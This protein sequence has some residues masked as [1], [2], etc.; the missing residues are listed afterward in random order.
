[1]LGLILS[2]LTAFA[3]AQLSTCAV[4]GTTYDVYGQP[5]ANVKIRLTRVEQSGQVISAIAK[6]VITATNGTWSMSVP[7]SST[8]WFCAPELPVAGISSNCNSPTKKTIPNA[9]SASFGALVTIVQSPTLGIT[10]K[11]EGTALANPIGTF[12]FVGSGVAVTESATGVATVTINGGGGG[13]GAVDSV[14]GRTGD[15]VAATNDYTFAQIDKTTS[16]LADLTTRSASDLSSGTLPDARFPATLPA[17]SGVNL[18]ALNASNLASGTVPLAR[19]SGIT[20]SQ[21]SGTAGITNA[22]LA[23]SIAYS[24]LSLTDSILNADINSAAAIAYSKLNLTGSILNADLAGSIANAKLANSGITIAGTSTSLGSAITLDT[25]TGLSSTGLVKRSGANTFAIAT[26]GTDYV[27]PGAATGSGLTMA[28]ARLLGR[29]TAS[30][31]AIEEITVGSGLSL[32]GGTLTASGGSGTGA[33]PSAPVG[34]SAVNGV[35]TTFMRSDGAPALSQSIVPTWTGIH[36]FNNGVT[37]GTTTTAGT[38]FTYNSLSTGTGLYVGS[39]STAGSSTTSALVDVSRSGAQ[40]GTVTTTAGRFSNTATGAG[41]TNN[42]LVLSASG[43]TAANY[44]LNVTVGDMWLQPTGRFFLSSAG[45]TT[46]NYIISGNTVSFNN[47][48]TVQGGWNGSGIYARRL[49]LDYA[50]GD[51]SLERRAARVLG[52]AQGDTSSTGPATISSGANTPAQITADQNNYTPGVGLFQRWSSDAA[53][54]VTGLLAGATDGQLAVI[55]NVG[56]QNIILANE[57]ASSTAANRFT[58]AS[59]ADITLAGGNVAFATYST[60]TSRW[61]VVKF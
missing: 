46:G 28:T 1:M 32:S 60:A 27:A 3:Q 6:D 56:A 52:I 57:S 15:V 20:T 13:G 38:V 47:N 5:K 11:D 14:F 37:T 43:A 26:S 35:A 7:R 4:S 48:A 33:D 61:L 39:T 31:G 50:N 29:T 24:K 44:A 42:A 55:W 18:T 9:A 45:T 49:T 23:G 36:T 53:R 8:A 19:L 17:A 30:S 59:G 25:I 58:S 40:T 51:V 22:Q 54:T 34:L 21:L 12:N 16:S 2:A 41:A 10:V